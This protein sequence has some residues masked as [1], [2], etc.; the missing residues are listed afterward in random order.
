MKS[1]SGTSGAVSLVSTGL[2]FNNNSAKRLQRVP[3]GKSQN[4]T[5]N[6]SQN[7]SE[8]KTRNESENESENGRRPKQK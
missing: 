4:K 7:K 8:N 6:K 3:R 1:L 5:Q 2:F